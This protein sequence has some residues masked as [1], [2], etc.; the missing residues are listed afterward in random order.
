MYV[1]WLLITGSVHLVLSGLRNYL[2][3]PGLVLPAVML[4]R[5]YGELL[6]E[7]KERHI[8]ALPTIEPIKIMRADGKT[9]LDAVRIN[10]SSNSTSKTSD[11]ANERYII[12][13]CA[14]GFLY[15]QILDYLHDYGA[16]TNATVFAFNYSGVG[17]SDGSPNT[18][19]VLY[20]DGM[21]VMEHVLGMGAKPENV[22]LHGHS[23]GA[24]VAT[25]VRSKYPGGP[26]VNDRSFSTF[27]AIATDVLGLIG[28]QGLAPWLQLVLPVAVFGPLMTRALQ[29][30]LGASEGGE[31]VGWMGYVLVVSIMIYSHFVSPIGRTLTRITVNGLSRYWNWTLPVTPMWRD[32][33]EHNKLIVF[34]RK[35]GVIP[36]ES[37]SLVSSLAGA[38]PK[39]I[40][41]VYELM[42]GSQHPPSPVFHNQLL[43]DNPSQWAEFTNIA[44]DM[45]WGRKAK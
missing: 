18:Q 40:G 37:S 10:R 11:P 32:L 25:H 24:A 15:E 39:E 1:K 19:D 44:K 2:L 36:F 12:Y 13:Y 38:T 9:H 31:D 27:P 4:G 29:A 21:A 16:R 26:I 14:N 6:D 5:Q 23:L 28:T 17:H 7:M 30:V 42:F 8:K 35:D 45:L 41:Q 20:A 22:L 43:K 34:H 3:V 33:P